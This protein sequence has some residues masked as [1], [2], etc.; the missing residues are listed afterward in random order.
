MRELEIIAKHPIKTHTI[1]VDDVRCMGTVYFDFV[2][3]DEV[4]KKIIAIN[5]NYS[6]H[7][8]NGEQGDNIFHDD[9]MIA[10]V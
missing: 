7:Y 9:I 5:P 3:R 10:K 6:I 8:E 2:P 1:L 4:I